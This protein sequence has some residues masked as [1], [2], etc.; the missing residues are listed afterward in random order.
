MWMLCAAPIGFG[1]RSNFGAIIWAAFCWTC[2]L[3]RIHARLPATL[4]RIVAIAL[5]LFLPDEAWLS[6][7]SRN[8]NRLRFCI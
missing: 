3:T 2:A 4:I 6:F 5:L 8:S 7:G 1:A